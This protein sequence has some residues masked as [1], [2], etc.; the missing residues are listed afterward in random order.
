MVV[1]KLVAHTGYGDVAASRPE[2]VDVLQLK[3]ECGIQPKT[4]PATRSK[5]TRLRD[6]KPQASG[7]CS[8]FCVCLQNV[9]CVCVQSTP[10]VICLF[11]E[12][13]KNVLSDAVVSLLLKNDCSVVRVCVQFD[14]CMHAVRYCASLCKT[15][16]KHRKEVCFILDVVHMVH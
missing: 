9:V 8:S 14:V 11:F 13:T 12:M 1:V 16:T 5:P 15:I 2:E 7:A 6:S 10:S 4:P 3:K